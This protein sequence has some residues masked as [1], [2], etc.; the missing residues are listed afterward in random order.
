MRTFASIA[1]LAGAVGEIIGPGP[2]FRVEQDRVNAFADATGD[3]QWIHIDPERAATGPYG[4]TVAHGYLT[5]SLLPALMQDVYQVKGVR[6]GINYGLNR[7]RF[8]APLRTGDAVRISAEIVAVEPVPGGVQLVTRVTVEPDRGG[9][10]CCVAE[11]VTRLYA[12]E[13]PG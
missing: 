7:V 4:T 6:M 10:P 9:K 11:T 1:E 12:E 3:H 2:W 5:L 13:E 8:P